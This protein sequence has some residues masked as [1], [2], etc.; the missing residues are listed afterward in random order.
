MLLALPTEDADAF[1]GAVEKLFSAAD[2][3]ELVALYQ[4]LPLL[5]YPERFLNLAIDGVRSNMTA[6]FNAIALQNPYPSEH[7]DDDA[8]NQVVLKALFVGSPLH[9][10]MGLDQRANA[11]LARML[12]DYAHERWAAGRPVNPELWRLVG[13]FAEGGLV[14]DLER[15]LASADEREQLAAALACASSPNSEAQALLDTVPSL[16]SRIWSGE[17]TWAT[18]H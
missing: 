5:P 6:V 10:M 17:L 7:F 11:K 13:P 12:S 14:A 3:G 18:L 2:V 4:A 15:V 1:V 9:P 16:K 8:W